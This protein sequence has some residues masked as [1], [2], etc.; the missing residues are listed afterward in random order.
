MIPTEKK[1]LWFPI[2]FGIVA[3]SFMPH[4]SCHYYRIETGSS[5]V[6][7]NLHYSEI[8]SLGSMAFYSVLI[9]LNLI[10][11]S[12]LSFRFMASLW[13]GLVH[14]TLGVV[15]II[16]LFDPFTF[17]VFG[18]PWSVSSSVREILIVFPFGILCI[19]FAINA[20]IKPE[21]KIYSNA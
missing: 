20:R 4:W 19:L 10:S 3:C 12:F 11:I 15:H 7:G 1:S 13:S 21:Y 17:E 6:V 16:R 5:F 14:L 9:G 18:Y 2:F 8:G